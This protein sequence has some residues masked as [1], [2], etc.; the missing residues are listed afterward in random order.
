M[1]FDALHTNTIKLLREIWLS[2]Y[3][4]VHAVIPLYYILSLWSG[5]IPDAD[6]LP[7]KIEREEVAIWIIIINIIKG[8]HTRDQIPKRFNYKACLDPR[9]RLWF[10]AGFSECASEF[11]T[12]KVLEVRTWPLLER[13]HSRPC[14]NR[15]GVFIIFAITSRS[16]VVFFLRGSQGFSLLPASGHIFFWCWPQRASSSLS[17]TRTLPLTGSTETGVYMFG[18]SHFHAYNRCQILAAWSRQ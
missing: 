9:A 7:R 16:K 14:Y 3:M 13:F 2:I 8:P 10:P 17:M 1:A 4:S 11:V 15:I 6:L 5:A 18:K 12:W